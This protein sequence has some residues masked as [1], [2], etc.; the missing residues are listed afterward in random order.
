MSD[1]EPSSFCQVP[2]AEQHRSIAEPRDRRADDL[3]QS[4]PRSGLGPYLDERACL[5]VLHARYGPEHE[6]DIFR[7]DEL[8]CRQSDRVAERPPEQVLGSMVSPL[9]H[10]LLIEHDHRIGKVVEQSG[11]EPVPEARPPPLQLIQSLLRYSP[12]AEF[13]RYRI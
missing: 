11:Q 4:P 12:L 6:L 8:E 2:E 9:Q 5:F 13:T 3:Q 1:L 10:E 7:V